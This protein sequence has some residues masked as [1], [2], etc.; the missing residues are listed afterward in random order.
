MNVFFRELKAYR[1]S[2]VV[3]IFSLCSL[4][5]VFLLMYPAFTRDVDTTR[6]IM[7]NLPAAVRSALDISLQNFF[8]IYGF[9]VYLFTFATVAGAVQAMNLGVGIISKEESGKTVDFL[10]TKPISRFKVFT[11]KLSASVILLLITNVFFCTASYVVARMVSTGDFNNKI[12]LMILITFLFVQLFFLALGILMSVVINKI[13][14]PIAAS[15]PTVFTF[16]VIGMLGSIIGSENVRYIS[17]FKFY[18]LNYVINNGQYEP[19][20]IV[21]ELVFVIVAVVTGY[22]LY[23]RKDI[24]AVS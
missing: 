16:F 14:S 10:L 24:R 7:E 12:F 21:I 5:T 6:Q 17:P 19:V 18:D 22:I 4:V 11:S 8:T 9:F 13:K 20:Y 2:T 15:L 23:S 3:W 1:N